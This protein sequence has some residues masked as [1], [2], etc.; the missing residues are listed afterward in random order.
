MVY[1]KKLIAVL[2]IIAFVFY[3][4]VT[5]HSQ[6]GDDISMQFHRAKTEYNNGQYISSKNRLERAIGTIKAKKSEKERKDILGKCYLLLG[7]IYE[8]EG[9]NNLAEENYKRAKQRYGIEAIEGVNLDDRPLYKRVVKREID[10]DR[11]FQDALVEY[12]NGQ[13]D[14]A[15]V[16]FERLIGT[17]KKEGLEVKKK[18][19][20]GK[21]YLLLGTV[22]EKK[23]EPLL[24]RENYKKARDEYKIQSVDNVDFKK[25]PIYLEIMTQGKIVK[26]GKKP[27]KKFPVLIVLAAAAAVAAVVLLLAQK[28]KKEYTLTVTRGDGVDGTPASGSSTYAEGSRVNYDYSL[29]TGYANLVVTLDG[30]AV[31]SSGTITMDGNHTL[32]ASAARLGQYT[33]TVTKGEGVAG[34]PDSGTHTYN[35]GDT[36]NYSYTP[37]SGYTDLVVQLDGETVASSGVIT[38]DAAHTLTASASAAAGPSVT[39]T[40]HQNGDNVSGRIDI[41]GSAQS[42]K[43]IDRVE[44][45]VNDNV[46]DTGADSSFSLRWN[47]KTVEDGI[48]TVKVTAYDTENTPGEAQVSLVVGNDTGPAVQIVNPLNNESITYGSKITIEASASSDAGIDRVIF[49]I[50]NTEVKTDSSSPY[51]YEWDTTGYAEGSHVIRVVAYDNSGDTA[52][53]QVT[54]TVTSQ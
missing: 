38:M 15:K 16:G 41:E 33:L 54:V 3:T 32:T 19:I 11:Q 2:A 20:L 14:K 50:D 5:L 49:Y 22:Y 27:K 4:S 18:D 17:A 43:G 12:G 44:L 28:K 9:K 35:D 31:S 8:K 53:H 10:I 30:A 24:A 29:Q 34:T 25:L 47:T 52:E 48:Y 37:Q 36:V 6:Q 46:I 7:A 13:Y 23:G 1:S 39:I 40:S 45:S 42:A 21:C 51:S 26:P